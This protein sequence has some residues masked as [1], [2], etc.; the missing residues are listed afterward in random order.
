MGPLRVRGPT[1]GDPQLKLT[2]GEIE[3]LEC[4]PGKKDSRVFDDEQRG[5]GVRVS[6]GA[7]KGS[8]VGKSYLVQYR[9]AGRKQRV[10]VG[11]CSAI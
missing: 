9:F 5:L 10:P 3:A 8:M 6:T 2:Q 11:A 4:L 1:S 7:R